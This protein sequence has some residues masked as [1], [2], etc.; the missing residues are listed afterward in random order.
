MK[1]KL[2]LLY[3]WLIRTILFFFPD[4]QFFMRIRGFLYG[5]FM[6]SCGKDFQVTHDAIIKD[7]FGISVGKH[8]FVGN[9]TVIMGSGTIVIEDEVQFAPHCIIISGNH[10]MKGGSFRYGEGDRGHIHIGR[11]AW[12]AGNST[13]QRGS[14]LP[15]G[16][17]LSANS[18]LNKVFEEPFSL[19]GGVPAKFIK[20]LEECSK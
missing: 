8:V 6:K 5:L 15:A 20:R 4:I 14:K 2:L 19:F 7:L 16:S 17:V 11:G 13:V 1:S 12:V 9:G 3:V 10:T 18:F